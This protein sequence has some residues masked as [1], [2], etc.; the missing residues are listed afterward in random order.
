MKNKIIPC[1]LLS[2]A[3]LYTEGSVDRNIYLKTDTFIKMKHLEN[4]TLSN[5]DKYQIYIMKEMIEQK[6]E[7]LDS[8]K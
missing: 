6:L 4:K 1:I 7:D 2:V 8:T 3:F 5:Y